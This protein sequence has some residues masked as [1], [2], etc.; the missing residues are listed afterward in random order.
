MIEPSYNH[1]SNWRGQT[2]RLDEIWITGCEKG[3]RSYRGDKARDNR[4]SANFSTQMIN[5]AFPALVNETQSTTDKGNLCTGD[6]GGF[7]TG[8][9]CG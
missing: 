7:S 8:K 5:W 2:R 1:F 3:A 6:K 4:I 9:R